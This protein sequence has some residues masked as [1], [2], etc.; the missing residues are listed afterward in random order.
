MLLFFSVSYLMLSLESQCST[1]IG[2][3]WL[4]QIDI[5]IKIMYIVNSIIFTSLSCSHFYF[6]TFSTHKK[7]AR[8][9]WDLN[10]KL[11]SKEKYLFLQSSDKNFRQYFI[12]FYKYLCVKQ[13]NFNCNLFFPDFIFFSRFYIFC[14]TFLILKLLHYFFLNTLI[15]FKNFK[16]SFFGFIKISIDVLIN[17]IS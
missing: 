14:P 3:K 8:I 10:W 11:I 16:H 2:L 7:F 13:K 6:V 1:G 17:V 5:Q 12:S 9:A 4:A 15:H